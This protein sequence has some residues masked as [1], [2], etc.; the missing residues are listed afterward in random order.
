M[1]YPMINGTEAGSNVMYLFRYSNEITNG[2]AM[3]LIVASFFLLILISSMMMQLRFSSRVR[4]DVAFLASSFAT[5]GFATIME[6]QTGL[7]N[8]LYFFIVI[9]LTIISV[10]WVSTSE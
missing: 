5:L 3:P 6:Q 2:F 4:P 7:L 8:P 1:V 9:G 10:L